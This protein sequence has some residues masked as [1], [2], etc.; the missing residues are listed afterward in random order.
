MRQASPS[1]WKHR[2]QLACRVAC[3]AALM[4]HMLKTSSIT[5]ATSWLC[6][7]NRPRH[8]RDFMCCSTRSLSASFILPY[9][10]AIALNMPR[11]AKTGMSHPVNVSE[12]SKLVLPPGAAVSRKRC[13][14]VNAASAGSQ[15]CVMTP[16]HVSVSHDAKCA[17]GCSGAGL[18][19][20]TL[21]MLTGW[22]Q[23]IRSRLCYAH[24]RQQ[25]TCMHMPAPR[26]CNEVAF[27]RNSR[28]LLQTST[29]GSN[30]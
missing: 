25:E 9:I 4:H 30:L 14:P 20:T 7:V 12:C 22:Q 28:G 3:A 27:H 26:A 13:R 17:G 16:H 15:Q 21:T 11:Q 29:V 10:P 18:Q 1:N 5:T 19:V 6:G 23:V 2:R 24:A 8:F